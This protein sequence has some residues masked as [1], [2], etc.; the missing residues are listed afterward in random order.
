M[1]EAA[2]ST[3][4]RRPAGRPGAARAD[5]HELA[6][7]R[8]A[9]MRPLLAALD[10]L[11]SSRSAVLLLGETG[12]GKDWTARYLHRRSA[13]PGPLITLSCESLS[14]QRL[15]SVLP[16]AAALAAALQGGTLRSWQG[17]TLLFHELGRLGGEA[18][19]R[20]VDLVDAIA[21]PGGDGSGGGPQ[22]D[23]RILATSTEDLALQVHRG[24]LLP[25]LYYRL[26]AV[27]LRLPPLRERPEDV[28][29]LVAVLLSELEQKYDL[30]PFAVTDALLETF[31]D[32]SWPGN[33]RQLRAVL[34]QA[35]V[36][37]TGD[38]LDVGTLPPGWASSETRRPLEISI[39]TSLADVEKRLILE[40][41]RAVGGRR[42]HAARLL[43]ISRRKLHYRL[44]QYR[45]EGLPL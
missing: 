33:I 9:A 20:L 41:L 38:L 30:G 43:G 45:E 2:L 7:A 5:E 32:A 35:M 31:R 39:G 24:E 27:E 13:R 21:A 11:A 17:G 1:K 16:P 28:E 18:Q 23:L 22:L 15:D 34:E 40:T 42:L 14:G 4:S 3:V 44:R 10:R 8:G 37:S 36:L 25:R 6:W 26:A 29:G 19:S 12:A